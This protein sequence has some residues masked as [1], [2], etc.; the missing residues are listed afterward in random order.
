[1]GRRANI[2]AGVESWDVGSGCSTKRT[3]PLFLG[4]NG[5]CC[6]VTILTMGEGARNRGFIRE[7]R[8]A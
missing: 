6:A 1:M 7:D 5:W 3:K 4:C 8:R 2:G